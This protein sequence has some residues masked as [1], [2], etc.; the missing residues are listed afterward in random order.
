MSSDGIHAQLSFPDE[1]TAERAYRICRMA[2]EQVPFTLHLATLHLTAPFTFFPTPGEYFPYTWRTPTPGQ[3][4]HLVS[5]HAQ[6]TFP[7]EAT[8]ERAYRI[9]RMAGEQVPQGREGERES[10]G[11]GESAWERECGSGSTW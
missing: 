11:V 3:P 4:L 6:L 8:A 9:C 7:D 1:A 5:I 2:G 10:V